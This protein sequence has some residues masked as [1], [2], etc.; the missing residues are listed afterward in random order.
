MPNDTT[1]KGP[2]DRSRIS[3][4]EPLAGRCWQ[5]CRHVLVV[6][7]RMHARR[8]VLAVSLSHSD[9]GCVKTRNAVVS[10]ATQKS[11]LLPRQSFH[12]LTAAPGQ[13]YLARASSADV[14]GLRPHPITPHNAL[15]P[16][17]KPPLYPIGDRV[18]MLRS[19]CCRPGISPVTVYVPRAVLSMRS[20]G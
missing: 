14:R 9:P 4:L 17:Y 8:D 19:G 7:F 11:N 1:N 13:T 16:T 3:L 10:R 5:T 18:T 6:G 20:D 2:Q 15:F 12:S